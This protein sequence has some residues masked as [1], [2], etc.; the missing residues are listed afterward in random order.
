[1]REALTAAT[2]DL[3]MSVIALA[4][5]GCGPQKVAICNRMFALKA[6]GTSSGSIY[7]IP[8]R[9]VTLFPKLGTVYQC[10]CSASVS[11]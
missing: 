10:M 8:F 11:I 1:M 2:H 7:Q 9:D 4:T 6:Q 3:V 5:P